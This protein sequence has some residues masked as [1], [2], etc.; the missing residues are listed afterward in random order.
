M[1]RK[2]RLLIQRLSNAPASK[3]IRMIFFLNVGLLF[4]QS[5]SWE[6]FLC[7]I[8]S[9]MSLF[10]NVINVKGNKNKEN[11]GLRCTGTSHPTLKKARTLLRDTWW[12]TASCLQSMPVDCLRSAVVP[13]TSFVLFFTPPQHEETQLH[14]LIRLISPTL[15]A[16]MCGATVIVGVTCLI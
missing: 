15:S 12:T 14:L 16:S 10:K 3:K 1:S 7:H 13:P 4:I 8:I 2:S 5:R 6:V 9:S 11:H